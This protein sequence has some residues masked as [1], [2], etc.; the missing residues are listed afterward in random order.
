MGVKGG[1][2]F[3]GGV[4]VAVGTATLRASEINGNLALGGEGDDGG[5]DGQ[6][7]GGG[8][9]IAPGVSACADLLTIIDGNHAST[10][11][12]DVFGTLGSC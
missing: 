3:G 12:D 6:G 11:D 5:A 7:V 1:N 10:S 9:Y 8:V 4:Y 2:G